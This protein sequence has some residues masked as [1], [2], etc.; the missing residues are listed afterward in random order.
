M[1]S[2]STATL[3]VGL[4]ADERRTLGRAL[5]AVREVLESSS[6]VDPNERSQAL[7]IVTET[8]AELETEEPNRLKVR[9]A[10]S[11]LA[12]TVRTMAASPQA[13]ELLKGAAALLGLQ[14]P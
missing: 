3:H 4:D 10:I 5:E 11:G 12:T 2:H 14:L 8:M 9:S 1:G 7:E 13:Y 6:A